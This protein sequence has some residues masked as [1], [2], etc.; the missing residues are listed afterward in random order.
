V[1]VKVIGINHGGQ[2]GRMWCLYAHPSHLYDDLY[3]KL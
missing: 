2:A 3:E 1:V